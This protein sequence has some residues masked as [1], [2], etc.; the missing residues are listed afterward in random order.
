MLN[1]FNKLFG[2]GQ[3]KLVVDESHVCVFF[4]QLSNNNNKTQM[5]PGNQYLS[6]RL[7][8]VT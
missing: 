1:K 3:I 2:I 7:I 4:D 5:P 8:L 6:G